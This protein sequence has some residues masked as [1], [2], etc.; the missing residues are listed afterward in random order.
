MSHV[1]RAAGKGRG[2]KKAAVP[3]QA[4]AHWDWENQRERIA[5]ALAGVADIDLW[6]LFRPASPDEPLLRTWSQGV[7]APSSA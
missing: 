1:V 2:R 6:K 7:R 4:M 5:R 3:S